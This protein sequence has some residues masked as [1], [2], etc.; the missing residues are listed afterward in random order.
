MLFK[1]IIIYLITEYIRPGDMFPSLGAI[2]FN[3]FIF[4]VFIF[5]VSF[6]H[7]RKTLNSYFLANIQGKLFL[8]LLL[9]HIVSLIM[10]QYLPELNAFRIYQL[11]RSLTGYVL[12]YFFL[13]NEIKDRGKLIKTIKVLILVHAFVIVMNYRVL[14]EGSHQD[15]L[16]SGNFFADGNDLAL[17]LNV[18]FPLAIYLM[19]NEIKTA[20][21]SFALI[22]ILF[23]IAIILTL[24]RGG[25]IGLVASLLYFILS[26]RRK[27][28]NSFLLLLITGVA[29]ISAPSTYFKR[30]DT[31][32]EY[33]SESSAQARILAWKGAVKISLDYPLIG[34]G[35]GNFVVIYAT[36]YKPEGFSIGGV[37]NAAHSIYFQTLAELGF[38]GLIA[39][40]GVIIGNVLANRRMR[41]KLPESKE[42]ELLNHFTMSWIGYGVN[43][44]FLSVLYYPHIFILSAL[45]V[46]AR[47]SLLAEKGIYN[48]ER[49][50]LTQS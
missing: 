37:W 48:N 10:S 27:F 12:V 26:G 22:S 16:Q 43:A 42:K 9:L 5:L 47:E 1:L 19:F 14:S 40:L 24:S 17:S 6:L 31:I 46:V 35:P 21:I 39:I 38:P 32:N 8:F 15:F 4:P 36:R 29:L 41:R 2:P 49:I 7:S 13:I 45:N 18:V 44:A 28:A 11:T 50:G 25:T 30:M 3:T 33:E 34:V 20:K 23:I